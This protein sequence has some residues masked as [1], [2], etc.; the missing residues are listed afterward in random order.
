MEAAQNIVVC[1]HLCLDI[2]PGFPAGHGA[3]DWFRPG[4][5][6]IVG[7]PVIS[8]G[9]AVSNVGLGL[10]SLGLPV[11]LA[12]RIGDDAIGKLVWDRVTASDPRLAAGIRRVDR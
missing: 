5:L 7:A 9:G 10:H 2:I 3:Q 8:T 4:G 11:R 6:S 1:G 12:A